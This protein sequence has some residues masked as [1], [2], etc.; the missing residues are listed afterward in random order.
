MGKTGHRAKSTSIIPS[1]G[2]TATFLTWSDFKGI[3]T[4]LTT[5]PSKTYQ[6]TSILQPTT[7]VL[8]EIRRDCM[9]RGRVKG[10]SSNKAEA[11][12]TTAS[13]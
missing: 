10:T 5:T 12:T 7:S 6:M 1:I 3:S 2:V 4:A 9:L 13:K 8:Q 11:E